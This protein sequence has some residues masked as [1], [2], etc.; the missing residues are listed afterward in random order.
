MKPEILELEEV[1]DQLGLES[2][3]QLVDLAILLGTDYNP[4]GVPGI[5][6]KRA[7]QLLRKCGW[8][9]GALIFG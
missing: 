2:R 9:L 7:L 8:L 6:P 4:D 1:L 3:E 5:G